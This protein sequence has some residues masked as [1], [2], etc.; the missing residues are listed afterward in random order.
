MEGPNWK[1]MPIPAARDDEYREVAWAKPNPTDK[2]VPVFI[3]RPKVNGH[4]VKFDMKYCGICHSD[5]TLGSN[6]LGNAMYPL[7]P[8]HELCGI[9]SDVGDKVTK[10]K[11]GDKVG[12]G[13]M[14]DACLDCQTCNDGDEM[15]CENGGSTHT[16]NT[17]KGKY[18]ALGKTSHFLGN[19]ETQTFGGYS[20]SQVVH[21][22]FIIKIPEAVPL[23]K[24][25]P[26]MCAGITMYTP[27]KHWGMKAAG[28]AGKVKTVGVVGLG[29]LGTMGVKLA[30][31][32]GH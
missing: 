17:M 3:N 15:L 14:I 21:E 13:C 18:E 6:D 28:E 30:K 26:I 23:E 19:P 16:Y 12:V 5:L 2:F 4:F 27:L 24:A 11:V 8:G 31:A 29:G 10:V 25:G 22:H 7:V 9:V 20:G 32:M 1:D